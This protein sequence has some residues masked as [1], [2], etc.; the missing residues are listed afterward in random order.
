MTRRRLILGLLLLT[1]LI[2]TGIGAAVPFFVSGLP[3]PAL[4]N[5]EE[6]LRWIVARDLAKESPET[7]LVLI[8]RLEEE[9]RDGIDWDTVGGKISDAQREQLW[10]NIPLLFGQWLG[11]KAAIYAH[12]SNAERSGFMDRILKTLL[13]W[14]G[15]NRLQAKQVGKDCTN[16]PHNLLCVFSDAVKAR[17]ENADPAEREHIS[18]FVDALQARVLALF[19]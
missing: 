4:A 15:V 12:L 5:R 17:K 3:N 9:F 16:P 2:A 10:K 1:A 18:Q 14:Q 8:R 19:M 7:C 11:D 13:S 6:L